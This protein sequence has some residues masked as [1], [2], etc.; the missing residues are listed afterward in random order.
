MN[1][2]MI[3]ETKTN[4][5]VISLVKSRDK[6]QVNRIGDEK[7]LSVQLRDNLDV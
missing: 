5:T 3:N 2:T 1:N 7:Q 6:A 4:K